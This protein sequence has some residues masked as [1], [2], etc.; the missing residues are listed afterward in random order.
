MLLVEKN[1]SLE[2]CSEE[3]DDVVMTILNESIRM[4][5]YELFSLTVFITHERFESTI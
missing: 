5:L 2:Q 1:K 3:M 4:K